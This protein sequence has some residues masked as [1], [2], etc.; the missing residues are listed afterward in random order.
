MA[1]GLMFDFWEK[2]LSS[3]CLD[4]LL[5][6]CFGLYYLGFE[7]TFFHAVM[8]TSWKIRSLPWFYM[9]KNICDPSSGHPFQNFRYLKF[10]PLCIFQLQLQ[11]KK[12]DDIALSVFFFR[13][14]HHLMDS[15]RATIKSVCCIWNSYI[16]GYKRIQS[17][18]LTLL[19]TAQRQHEKLCLLLWVFLWPDYF[20]Y[21]ILFYLWLVYLFW[22][23]G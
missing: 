18:E 2:F 7:I 20:A 10:I 9:K 4:L 17:C 23:M 12:Y 16:M 22:V 3:M 5:H 21:C 19:R 8:N 11:K 15:L 6:S 13:P 14:K 1:D